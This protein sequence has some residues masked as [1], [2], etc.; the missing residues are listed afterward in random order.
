MRIHPELRG[1]LTR[2][3]EGNVGGARVSGDGSTVVWDQYSGEDWEVMRHKDGR[4]LCLSKDPAQDTGASVS[5]D[6]ET[7]VWERAIGEDP[8]DPQFHHDV[9]MWR[10]G[11]QKVIAGSTADETEPA[12]SADGHTVVYVR[13]D[14]FGTS[15]T[16]DLHSWKEGEAGIVTGGDGLDRHPQV[17]EHGV[18]VYFN[19]VLQ[20]KSDLWLRDEAG[21]VKRLTWND[22][23]EHDPA[24]SAD[25]KVLSWTQKDN[26][27]DHALYLY[28]TVGKN[29]EVRYSVPG[30]QA[31]DPSLSG[32]GSTLAFTRRSTE[33]VQVMLSE[34]GRTL[35][36]NLDGGAFQPQ[37]SRDGKVIV[38]TALDPEHPGQLGIY[39][40][41][42]EG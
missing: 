3:A 25:G 4:T 33:G 1:T 27:R 14:F 9:I 5:H 21:A 28:D 31:M 15:E 12:I 7:V 34:G 19:R 22:G 10:S 18:R 8:F 6:G 36:L 13:D 24:I 2:I 30:E 38:F 41:D 20:G 39:R 32:D 35:P 42:R 26:E 40:F 37:V 23:T 29:P 16:Y 17:D 11:E